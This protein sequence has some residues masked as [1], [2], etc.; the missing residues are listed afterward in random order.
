MKKTVIPFVVSNP[1][2]VHEYF[3]KKTWGIKGINR[4]YTEHGIDKIGS[5]R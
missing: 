5:N 2:T 1:A 4:D 3:E